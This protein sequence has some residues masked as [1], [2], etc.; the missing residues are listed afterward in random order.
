MKPGASWGTRISLLALVVICLGIAWR[1]SPETPAPAVAKAAAGRKAAGPERSSDA[2]A[3]SSGLEAL[4]EKVQQPRTDAGAQ[5]APWGYRLDQPARTIELPAVLDQI[6]DLAAADSTGL[7][8]VND[9]DEKG[10][11]YRLSLKDG[12]LVRTIHFGP[13]GDY[14]GISEVDGGV[15]VARNDGV[16]FMIDLQDGG[17]TSFDTHLGPDCNLEGVA[18]DSY[19]KRLLLACKSALPKVPHSRK[20]V[21]VYAMSL[22]TQS[23]QRQP[24]I[25][26]PRQAIDDYVATHPDQPD[27]KPAMG[28]EF[29]PKAIAVHPTTG[30]IFMLSARGSM[31]VV[32]AQTGTLQRVEAL[33][34]VAHPQPEGLA[35]GPDGTLYI[36]DKSRGSRAHVKGYAQVKGL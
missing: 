13:G 11:A 24:V 12:S 15:I 20:S 6:S 22:N 32:L 34:R 21:G 29:A 30:Q 28:D 36:S 14:E 35:F 16:L 26:I 3:V 1:L 25:V 4:F 2:G 9:E 27:L 10:T 17:T 8:A 23:V 19:R 31:L 18:Y 33:D 5:A 7:W